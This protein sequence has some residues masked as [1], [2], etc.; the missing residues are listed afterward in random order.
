MSSLVSHLL[1]GLLLAAN[2]APDKA[3]TE[4]PGEG[5]KKTCEK[6]NAADCLKLA[7]M[8]ARGDGLAK[9]AS[10]ASD[11]YKKGCDLGDVTACKEGADASEHATNGAKKDTRAAKK[12]LEKACTLG[13]QP[14][15]DHAKDLKAG[16]K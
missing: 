14:A 1:A 9:D 3:K 11:F 5:L 8:Y 10:K 15:C 6:G 13:D 2:P 16:K 12:M 7:G 4:G